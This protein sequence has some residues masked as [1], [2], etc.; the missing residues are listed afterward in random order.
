MNKL[1]NSPAYISAFLLPCLCLTTLY[2]LIGVYPFGSAS[3]YYWDME[4]QYHDFFCWF[5]DVL[6]GNAGVEYSFSKS[7]GGSPIAIIG[8]YLMSPVNLLLVFFKKSQIQ[9]FVYV[10]TCIKLG[11]CGLF[12]YTFVFKRFKIPKKFCLILSLAY[13]FTQY[14]VSQA[15]NLMWLD[16]MYM[17]PLMMLGIYYY[18]KNGKRLLFYIS[19]A[20]SIVFC[21]YTG[22]M[23]CIFAVLYYL[24]ETALISK[25]FELKAQLKKL[26]GFLV[27]EFSAVLLSCVIFLPVL[28]GQSSGRTFDEGIFDFTTNGSLFDILKG[29]IIGSDFPSWQ[30]TLFCTTAVLLFFFSF[31]FSKQALRK[32][33]AALGGLF[34]FMVASMFFKPL[35][36]MWC[37]F[38]FEWSYMYRFAYLTIMVVVFI[39]AFGIE[40]LYSCDNSAVT[41]KSLIYGGV[42]FIF[43]LILADWKYGFEPK[44]LW[45]E[46]L[47]ILL[48][49]SIYVFFANKSKIKK[50]KLRATANVAVTL[51]FL[52]VFIFEILF[53]AK[54]VAAD[55]YNSDASHNSEYTAMQQELADTV[56]SSDSGFYR[57][58]QTTSRGGASSKFYANEPL[59][60]GYAG[61]QTYTSCYDS[62]TSQIIRDSGYC[63]E[64]YPSFYNNPILPMDSFLGIKYLLTDKVYSGYEPTDLKG[65]NGKE[66]YCNKYALSLGFRAEDTIIGQLDHSNSFEY[67]NALY[68]AVLGEKTEV[69]KSCVGY[70]TL[71]NE[72]DIIYGFNSTDKAGNNLLYVSF[73]NPA[74][75]CA[76]LCVNSEM[77][78]AY[79]KVTWGTWN[80]VCYLG[81]TSSIEEV[82][83]IN[84][85]LS[86]D[87]TNANFYYLDMNTFENAISRLQ[88]RAVEISKM[89]DGYVSAD[90]SAVKDGYV[91]FTVPYEDGWSVT[92]NGVKVETVAGAGQ[93]LSVPVIQGENKIV[94]IYNMRG[95]YAGICLS[96]VSIMIFVLSGQIRK[97]N[98]VEKGNR[99]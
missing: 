56:A 92:V 55:N 98:C 14:A 68:S 18:V 1:K 38:K 53:N 20:C 28:L 79:D 5:K 11:F 25:K 32:E 21:W 57:V 9:L 42:A 91:L 12:S 89:R 97:R 30:I 95:K 26:C 37:G 52:A 80:N 34:G 45:L 27:T 54:I 48:Y 63:T 47:L 94:M 17:L 58:E 41:D 51:C 10:A 88:S 35:E 23:N 85:N 84:C 22:Y 93:Y 65:A 59:A 19:T 44:R 40:K 73:E 64:E 87:E 31:W 76:S 29:F 33:K 96:V 66:V 72:N 7:L 2:I 46:I 77:I 74:I 24:C 50:Q 15:S 16:G 43:I 36:N 60:Y 71:Q 4:I 6:A 70:S 61:I 8:Y 62:A 78:S 90:Y 86:A 81:E 82:S 3:N 49:A 75:S 39:A 69:F 99:E 13:S 67:A 83:L